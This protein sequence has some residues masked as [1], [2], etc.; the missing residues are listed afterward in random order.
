[1]RLQ[2]VQPIPKSRR[3]IY[4]MRGVGCVRIRGTER[5]EGKNH[6]ILQLYSQAK[7]QL[8]AQSLLN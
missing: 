2:K 6:T 4:N 8:P 5:I 1:M 7:K 3:W